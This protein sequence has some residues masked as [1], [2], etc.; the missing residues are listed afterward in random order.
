MAKKF[1]QTEWQGIK[2][3]EFAKLSLTSLPSSQF[4]SDFYRIFY[5]R[6]PSWTDI[7]SKWRDEKRQLSEFILTKVEDKSKVLAVGCGLG[8][9]E[10]FIKQNKPD[11]DLFIHE[12]ASTSWRWVESEFPE[13]HKL[14]GWIPECLPDSIR[15]DLVY[16]LAVD[17]AVDD[18]SLVKM[19]NSLRSKLKE[20]GTCLLIS[21]NYLKSNNNLSDRLRRIVSAGKLYIM[22]VL[23]QRRLLPKKQFWGWM[24]TKEDYTKIMVESGFQN[25]SDGFVNVNGNGLYFITG[26]S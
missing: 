20:G 17:Y 15:F 3:E 26:N 14:I 23:K 12:V 19:L 21:V 16:L 5:E 25:V 8:L 9:T 18:E 4:Y 7:S 13:D 24:R 10:T 22:D 1:Y 2:F 11:T 6:F